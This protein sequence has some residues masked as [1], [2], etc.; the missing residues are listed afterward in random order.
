M[1]W[2]WVLLPI[3]VL[4]FYRLGYL[5]GRRDGIHWCRT[6]LSKGPDPAVRL[7]PGEAILPH[8]VQD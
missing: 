7:Y 4:G 6:E 8:E 1:T 5:R 2:E 3:F